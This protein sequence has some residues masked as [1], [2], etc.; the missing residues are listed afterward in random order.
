MLL[1][2]LAKMSNFELLKHPYVRVQANSVIR[3]FLTNPPNLFGSLD[4]AQNPGG[5]PSLPTASPVLAR[6][7]RFLAQTTMMMAMDVAKARTTALRR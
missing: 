6:R 7:Q 3:L 4:A 5:P 2:E 1:A